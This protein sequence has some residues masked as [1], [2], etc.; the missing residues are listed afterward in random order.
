M[1]SKWIYLYIVR[2]TIAIDSK[3]NGRFHQKLVS[4]EDLFGNKFYFLYQNLKIL[5]ILILLVYLSVIYG[6]LDDTNWI[7]LIKELSFSMLFAFEY[8]NKIKQIIKTND[9]IL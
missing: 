8:D 4:M 1:Y 6:V 2:D 5:N 9:F 7:N 3:E